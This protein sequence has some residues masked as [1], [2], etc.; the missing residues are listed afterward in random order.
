MPGREVKT[1]PESSQQ[2]H[3]VVLGNKGIEKGP[4]LGKGLV[5]ADEDTTPTAKA[6]IPYLEADLTPPGEDH[7]NPS[8]KTGTEQGDE[9]LT[10]LREDLSK[11]TVQQ[12]SE[13]P[14]KSAL[15]PG[16]VGMLPLRPEMVLRR[17]QLFS[18]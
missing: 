3:V 13:A 6:E 8:D 7:K 9:S 2:S 14:K 1:P 12:G 4:E 5:Q 15:G 11:T 10:L 16:V 17:T 18:S